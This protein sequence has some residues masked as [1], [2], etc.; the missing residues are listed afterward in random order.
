MHLST[1]SHPFMLCLAAA[2]PLI[3]VLALLDILLSFRRRDPLSYH[4]M[5][6][7]YLPCHRPCTSI[8]YTQEHFLL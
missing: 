6:Q 7:R 4:D 2:R 5:L 3:H 1:I 8:R